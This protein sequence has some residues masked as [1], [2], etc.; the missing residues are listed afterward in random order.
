MSSPLSSPHL[1]LCCV[2]LSTCGISVSACPTDAPNARLSRA[3]PSTSPRPSPAPLPWRGALVSPPLFLTSVVSLFL[4][5]L[6]QLCPA[7]TSAYFCPHGFSSCC[8]CR[9]PPP[10][11]CG[12]ISVCLTLLL[13][14]SL[15]L[16]GLCTTHTMMTLAWGSARAGGALLWGIIFH[17]IS[18]G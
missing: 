9:S 1:F 4:P 11:L 3:A 15:F 13:C 10:C 12:C 2:H 17:L 7:T 6:P 18:E 8:A 14:L 16:H 5:S